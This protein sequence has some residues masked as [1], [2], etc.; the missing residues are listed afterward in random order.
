MVYGDTDSL[1][2]L[3]EPG[4]D[5]KAL[6]E[7]VN[8]FVKVFGEGFSVKLEGVHSKLGIYSAKNYI[9]LTSGGE[10]IIKGFH[11]YHV[12]SAVK[13]S[14]PEI[15]RRVLEGRSLERLLKKS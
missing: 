9:C 14:L 2:I 8:K 13:E 12:P 1:F 7:A 5:P 11:R 6:E 15:V 10:V 3:L 4:D